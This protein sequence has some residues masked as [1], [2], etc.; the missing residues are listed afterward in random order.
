MSNRLGRDESRYEEE[1]KGQQTGGFG[2]PSV[3]QG[4]D[5]ASGELA[6]LDDDAA[7]RYSYR[8]AVV[9]S[10]R[11]ARV[12]GSRFAKSATVASPAA[13]TA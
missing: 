4:L 7:P 3:E 11:A 5:A 13:T 10:T 2:L 1:R 8:S 12:A 9:G 6:P